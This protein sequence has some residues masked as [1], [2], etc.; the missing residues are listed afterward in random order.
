MDESWSW[1]QKARL[2]P[3]GVYTQANNGSHETCLHKHFDE[4]NNILKTTKLFLVK[5]I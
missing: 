1:W 3:A 5:Y 2:R 4:H